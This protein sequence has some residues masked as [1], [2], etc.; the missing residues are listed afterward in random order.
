MR[1]PRPLR[2]VLGVAVSCTVASTLL[3]APAQAANA[4]VYAALGDSYSSGVGTGNYTSDSGSCRRS[5]QAYAPL[6][7]SAHGTTSFS[8]VACSGAVTADVLNNQL[9]VLNSSTTLVTIS[10][11]GNDAG[12]ADVVTTCKLSSDSACASAVTNAESF[13]RTTLPGRLANVYSQIKARAPYAQLVVLGYPRLFE[14]VSNCGWFSI[15]LYKRTKL[16][17]GADVIAGVISAQASASGA[18]YVDVR[19]AFAGHGVCAS[20][21]WINGTVWPVDDSYHPNA[22]GYRYGYLSAL[23]GAIG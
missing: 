5:N 19:S 16:D 11:G 2:W 9:G 23:T 14:L 7:A 15:D 10:I 22:S 12:F 20:S 8:F 3:A 6:Y 4:S 13:A 21:P 18:R 1:I 17:E